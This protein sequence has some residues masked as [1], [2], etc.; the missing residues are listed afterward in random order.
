MSSTVVVPVS[1]SVGAASTANYQSLST[2]IA[3][4][5]NRT[6]LTD[7]IPD[8]VRMAESEF[9]RDTRLRSSF[10]VV[11]SDGYAP[12]GELPL[13]TDMLE[14]KELAFGGTPL[15]QLPY[16]DWRVR[17]SGPYF[18]RVGNVA[19]VTGKPAGAYTLKYVQKLPALSFPSDSNWLLREHYDVYLWKC[20]EQGSVWMR[21]IEATQGYNSKYE[22]AVQQLL[23]SINYHAWGGASF[24]VQAPGVV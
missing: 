6:D 23:A 7:V 10:Q 15:T 13:P 2:S 5:L 19:H 12:A 17:A 8:F 1:N 22:A 14:L 3:K 11:V 18:S 21:D 16:E 9:A 20:C 4:W 24:A